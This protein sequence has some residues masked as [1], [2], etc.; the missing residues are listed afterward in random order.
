MANLRDIARTIFDQA[1]AEC[2]VEQ[3]VARQVSVHG[4]TLH[5]GEETID[6]RGIQRHPDNCSRKSR[7]P[8]AFFIASAT[9]IARRLRSGWSA[10]RARGFA[11]GRFSTA[12][13]ISIFSR[14]PSIAERSVLCRRTCGIGMLQEL[15]RDSPDKT[16][17]FFLISGGA[18]A[19]ME[20]PLD[21]SISLEDTANFHRTLV[22][23]GAS[24]AE[25][26]C[27]R[28]HFSAVKGGRL[29]LAAGQAICRSLLISDVPVGH[30]DALGSGPTFPTLL[31]LPNAERFWSITICS[32][33][34]PLPY[35]VSLSRTHWSKTPKAA[36]SYTLKPWFC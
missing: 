18:S 29:A 17:C 23:S 13:N 36:R 1:L 26:N 8:N 4:E 15:R 14:W 9:N 24:I 28:K 11:A 19:M 27:V 10:H 2:S 34:F 33:N 25:I 21:P 6:L 35:A 5:M 22:A 3:A 16:L 7:Q 32:R 20:L 12:E 30:E 31:R